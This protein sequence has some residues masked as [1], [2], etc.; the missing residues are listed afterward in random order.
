M[1]GRGGAEGRART[2]RLSLSEAPA[3][4]ESAAKF[5][6][7]DSALARNGGWGEGIGAMGRA[8]GGGVGGKEQRVRPGGDRG[9]Q[10]V[11]IQ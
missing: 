5:T 7:A 6:Q 11:S 10:G 9:G 1:G 2:R 3:P 8:S 4:A